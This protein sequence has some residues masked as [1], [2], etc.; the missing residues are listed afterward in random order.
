MACDATSLL[1]LASANGYGKLS[2]RQLDECIA[3][4]A[5]QHSFAIVP[6]DPVLDDPPTGP[7]GATGFTSTWQP[8]M[9]ATGYRID[10]SGDGFATFVPGF[11][12]L[13]VGNVLLK[14][15]TGLT[16]NT[17]YSVRVRA[18]NGSGTSGNSNVVNVKTFT[19]LSWSP[20]SATV[21]WF[22]NFT[23]KIGNLSTFNEQA[24]F[25]SVNQLNF[26]DGTATAISGLSSL[27]S[28]TLVTLLAN[29]SLI[30]TIDISGQQALTDVEF[31]QSALTVTAVNTILTTLDGYGL[32][33]GTVDL[34]GQTPAAP[35]SGA[36][37]ASAA[38]L[39][40]KGWTVTTD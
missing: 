19:A 6:S 33:N 2:K 27:N 10:V 30:T 39:S 26:N 9:G 4:Q 14:A 24:D 25:A 37:A 32:H 3:Y 21:F 40:G 35:P 38:N 17:P 11:N 34:S 28:Q 29:G 7:V 22:D 1:A 20:S 36:G 23:G 8:S 18:Y 16:A 31:N 15:V 12:N 13:D 5:S